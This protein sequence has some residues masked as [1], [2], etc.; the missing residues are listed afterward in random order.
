MRWGH[1]VQVKG[2]ELSAN[3]MIEWLAKNG[4]GYGWTRVNE[5]EALKYAKD[6][7]FVM[8]TWHSG[9]PKPGHVA[10]LLE[11]GSI[12][13]AGGGMPFV[14]QSVNTGFGRLPVGYWAYVEPVKPQGS[15]R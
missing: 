10:V 6:G 3:A 5:E 11:D 4:H 12:A 14:G 2:R 15:D 7:K 9:S 1:G 13:Q 8:V